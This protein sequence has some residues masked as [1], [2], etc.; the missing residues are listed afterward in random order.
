MATTEIDCGADVA[1]ILRLSAETYESKTTDYGSSWR[2]IGHI[3]HLLA[4]GEPIVLETP[5]DIIAFGLFTR[6]MDKFAREFNGTFL[7]ESLTFEALAD[8]PED[9]SV[10]AAMAAANIR[11]MEDR[12]MT[13]PNRVG[14]GAK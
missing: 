6:R 10:Y 11:D 9:E 7:S 12:E 3:I 1:E 8:S 4:R 13:D 14:I 5:E 2:A